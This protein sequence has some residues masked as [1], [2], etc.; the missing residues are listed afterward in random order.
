MGCF[1]GQTNCVS[2]LSI[3]LH[4]NQLD[5]KYVLRYQEFAQEIPFFSCF[6][7]DM[8]L[9]LVFLCFFFFSRVEECVPLN[10]SMCVDPLSLYKF[11]VIL[12]H[13]P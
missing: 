10:Y 5:S 2:Y 6:L 3:I 4:A 12:L 9:A 13:S 11:V 1:S 7:L 8:Q